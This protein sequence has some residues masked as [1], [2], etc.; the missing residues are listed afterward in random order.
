MSQQT[1]QPVK[2]LRGTLRVPGDK[3]ISH[4]ALM[5]LGISEGTAQIRGLLNSEDVGRTAANMAALGA[6]IQQGGEIVSV[7]GQGLHGLHPAT[8]PLYCGNSGTT[9]RIMT[10][11]LAG[12]TFDSSLSG[13][14]SLDRRPM[15]RVLQP[16]SQMGAHIKEVREEGRRVIKVAGTQLAGI[17]YQSPV[18]SAQ[19]KS[20]LLLAGLYANAPVRVEE[21][22][23]SRDHTE[24]MLA[25]LGARI[26]YGAAWAE[27]EPGGTL[28]ARDITVP[29]DFS[30]AA[31]FLVA[32]LI[33]PDSSVTIQDVL[34]NPTRT[35]LLEILQEMGGDIRIDNQRELGGETIADLH[36]S[37][38]DLRAID[39][40][41]DRIPSLIDEIPILAVAASAASGTTRIRGAAELRLKETDRLRALAAA[42]KI[43]GV[44]LEEE[45]DSLSIMGPTRIQGG[46]VKSYGDHRM[47]MA[48]TVAAGIASA[49][50]T[51][52][53]YD[54]TAVSYP[55]FLADWNKLTT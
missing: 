10:G 23:P 6:G 32:A 21:S 31:F 42:L 30:S 15:D 2:Q 7:T 29:T 14:A 27:L 9:L 4:R 17:T 13:D 53:D 40:P 1:I 28:Q 44:S 19:V 34:L 18:A 3:S 16:L 39:C 24:R 38:S 22:H 5:L 49:P 46:S 20:A 37:S 43:L 47:A 52:E 48:L 50:V 55:G 11:L 12:Q 8:K 41:P 26:R 35:G 25:H 51:I 54:C 33:T 36:V 45:P